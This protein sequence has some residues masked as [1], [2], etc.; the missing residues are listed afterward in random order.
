MNLNL[1]SKTKTL[2]WTS[3]LQSD[4][5][6][7]AWPLVLLLMLPL[8]LLLVL[9]PPCP[10]QRTWW[11][12]WVSWLFLLISI[13]ALFCK[14]VIPTFY[15][16][17]SPTLVQTPWTILNPTPTLFH[18]KQTTFHSAFNV[19]ICFSFFPCACVPNSSIEI[20]CF[21]LCA[22]AF[23]TPSYSASEQKTQKQKKRNQGFNFVK[24]IFQVKEIKFTGR[25][26]KRHNTGVHSKKVISP[27]VHLKKKKG[28]RSDVRSQIPGTT[29]EERCVTITPY[30]IGCYLSCWPKY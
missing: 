25:K 19:L 1:N 16:P 9:L 4:W 13:G 18:R 15:N 23:K 14:I 27:S 30:G 11:K 12:T 29:V 26:K 5:T 20:R 3:C 10:T 17:H 8:L 2:E 6:L 21:F 28:G 22:C 24:G 7:S